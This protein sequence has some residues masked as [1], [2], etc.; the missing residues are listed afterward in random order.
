MSRRRNSTSAMTIAA[1]LTTTAVVGGL[2][3]A[4]S[5]PKKKE[6]TK[7]ASKPLNLITVTT[8][9]EWDAVVS[10][11]LGEGTV[12]LSVS[13]DVKPLK[14]A[15]TSIARTYG[16]GEATVMNQSTKKQEKIVI[17]AGAK[18]AVVQLEGTVATLT[19]V[20]GGNLRTK[21]APGTNGMISLVIYEGE[22]GEMTLEL[23]TPVDKLPTFEVQAVEPTTPTSAVVVIPVSVYKAMVAARVAAITGDDAE[24]AL[25]EVEEQLA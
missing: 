11:L 24:Q 1:V 20:A 2:A 22:G 16:A 3:Y 8:Q 6:E 9:A 18:L 25:A 5:R 10:K 21:A 15:L 19:N 14:G 12:V 7:K 13:G 17:F 4:A 23:G